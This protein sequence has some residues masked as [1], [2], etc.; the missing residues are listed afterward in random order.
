MKQRNATQL[1]LVQTASSDLKN[2]YEVYMR[3]LANGEPFSAL[4]DENPDRQR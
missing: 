2:R 1:H 4:L 3:K